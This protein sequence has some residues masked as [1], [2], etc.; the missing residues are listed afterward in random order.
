MWEMANVVWKDRLGKIFLLYCQ[1]EKQKKLLRSHKKICVFV[2]KHAY[3]QDPHQFHCVVELNSCLSPGLQENA[4]RNPNGTC[5]Y[6][7]R[8]PR[9]N[10]CQ[11]LIHTCVYEEA[12]CSLQNNGP[13]SALGAGHRSRL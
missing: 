10:L 2:L 9:K 13:N 3:F 6:A 5:S 1:L 11:A 7:L 8:F 12:T 4:C